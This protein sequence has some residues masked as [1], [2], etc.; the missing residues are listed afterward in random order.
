MPMIPFLIPR[1]SVTNGE[2]VKK[3]VTLIL[4][5]QL[6]RFAETMS[7]LSAS[8]SQ[9]LLS[10][11]ESVLWFKFGFGAKFLN[12]VQFLFSFVMYSLPLK[13]EECLNIL[14]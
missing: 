9:V 3:N 12:L 13:N 10:S 11:L 7:E 2:R 8:H 4:W 5:E 14:Q 6:G 1:K